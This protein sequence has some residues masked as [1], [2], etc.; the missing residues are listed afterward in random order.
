MSVVNVE[1]L[2]VDVVC[3]KNKECPFYKYMNTMM[4]M[5]RQ[6]VTYSPIDQEKIK[7]RRIDSS[8]ITIKDFEIWLYGGH[9]CS[10]SEI[11]IRNFNAKVFDRCLKASDLLSQEQIYHLSYYN[12]FRSFFNLHILPLKQNVRL[13][14]VVRELEMSKDLSKEHYYLY[15]KDID[16]FQLFEQGVISQEEDR[17]KYLHINREDY[18][19]LT[20]QGDYVKRKR[21]IKLLEQEYF[22]YVKQNYHQDEIFQMY[23]LFQLRNPLEVPLWANMY[24]DS[25][26]FNFHMERQYP[27]YVDVIRSIQDEGRL[28]IVGDGPGT[29]SLAAWKVGRDYISVEP[30][31]IGDIAKQIGLIKGSRDE[32]DK[33]NDILLLFNVSQYLTELERKDFF[34]FFNMIIIDEAMSEDYMELKKRMN[35]LQKRR[36]VYRPLIAHSRGAGKVFFKGVK[37]GDIMMFPLENTRYLLNRGGQKVNPMDYRSMVAADLMGITVAGEGKPIC[38]D[39]MEYMNIITK[40]DPTDKRARDTSSIKL[41]DGNYIK[42]Y[43]G[44]NLL[45]LLDSRVVRYFHDYNSL[46]YAKDYVLCDEFYYVRTPVPHRLQYIKTREDGF[47][48]VYL[49]KKMVQGGVLFGVYRDYRHIMATQL[50]HVADVYNENDSEQ[51]TI[52]DDFMGGSG[53]QDGKDRMPVK[54][55]R[56]YELMR[57]LEIDRLSNT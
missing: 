30:N 36:G 7:G 48:K 1:V 19:F 8:I 4:K 22:E 49:I 3:D 35:G 13:E 32:V 33:Q 17:Q 56:Y 6:P 47:V 42:A 31:E 57:K 2:E 54:D 11:K 25:C 34:S 43:P 5:F 20:D 16:I 46:R 28:F 14:V 24:N 45:S 39:E 38:L 21:G 44:K 37:L 26:S 15:F 50:A 29:A 23:K 12:W 9:C 10:L 41:V 55:S 51:A 27:Q 40:N 53:I 52:D 18:D